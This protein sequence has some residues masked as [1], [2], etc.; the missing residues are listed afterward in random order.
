MPVASSKPSP[1]PTVTLS[2]GPEHRVDA[3]LQAN[4]R[5]SLLISGDVNEGLD[6]QKVQT[7]LESL[8]RTLQGL[9]FNVR[10]VEQINSIGVRAWLLFIESSQK[11]YPCTFVEVGESFIEQAS[12]V[13]TLL[14]A[15]GTPVL[16]FE[17]P[18][19][20]PA[21][22]LRQLKLLQ[23][24]EVRVDKDEFHYPDHRCEKCNGSTDFDALED[25]YFNFLRRS[26]SAPKL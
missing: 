4:G 11:K 2:E 15:Q 18:Y 6:F 10:G 19:F 1:M 25:E 13:P 16:A 14:G 3:Q 5:V 12:I 22:K 9:D 26:G 20:C 24:S 8:G 7:N 21:C 17:A 23:A